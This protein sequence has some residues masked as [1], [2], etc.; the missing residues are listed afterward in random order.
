MALTSHQLVEIEGTSQATNRN[1]AMNVGI[2]EML[3]EYCWW[4][5]KLVGIEDIKVPNW[6]LR[7]HQATNWNF[8]FIKILSMH[9]MLKV[10]C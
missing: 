3:Q 5:I 6:K 2:H 10:L 1:K 4:E 9:A 7:E 8:E